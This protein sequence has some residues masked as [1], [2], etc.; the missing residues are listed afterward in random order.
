MPREHA[1][2]QLNRSEIMSR[3]RGQN[4]TPERTLRR[5]L[6]LKGLRYRLH[7][8]LPGRPDIVFP[9]PHVAV[10]VDGCFWHGCPLHYSSPTRRHEYWAR[11][12]RSNVL[13]DI[14]ADRALLDDGWEVVR[15]WQHDLRRQNLVVRAIEERLLVSKYTNAKAPADCSSIADCPGTAPELADS[16]PRY[17]L[18]CTCGKANFKVVGVSGPGSLRPKGRRAP[19]WIELICCCCAGATRVVL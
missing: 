7:S 15:V 13:R 14:Q 17:G 6:R 4:T 5:L 3:V 11:K 8:D 18:V 16:D 19:A 10:F 2:H 12:L 9:G 1:A